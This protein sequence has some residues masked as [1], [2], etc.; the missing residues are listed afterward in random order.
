MALT[1]PA[2]V[3]VSSTAIIVLAANAK[4]KYAVIQNLSSN[5][6]RVGSASVTASTGIRLAQYDRLVL[7]GVSVPTE[8]IYAIREGGSDGSCVALQYVEG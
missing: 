1:N 8:D 4:R 6:V 7:E 2:A 3:T 5:A